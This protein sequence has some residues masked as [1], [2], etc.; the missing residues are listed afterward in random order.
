MF[1]IKTVRKAIKKVKSTLIKVDRRKW[2]ECSQEFENTFLLFVTNKCNLN[3]FH[4]FNRSNLNNHNVLDMNLQYVRK[5]VEAN[6]EVNKYDIMGGEP[7]LHK[8]INEI[9]E[10]LSEQNKKVGLYTNGYLLR[11]LETNHKN[12]KIGIST[13]SLYSTNKALRPLV[14]IS[15]NIKQYQKFYPIKLVFLI[16][17]HNVSILKKITEYVEKNFARINKLTIGLV[18]NE[19]DYWS[20]N[21]EYVLPFKE[22]GD[23]IQKFLDNYIGHLDIDIFTKG[24]L[25]THNLPTN[26]KHQI[27]RFK[28]IFPDMSYIPCLYLVASNKKFPIGKNYKIP[29]PQFNKCARTGKRRCMADK[30]CLINKEGSLLN[31]K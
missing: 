27:C 12:L 19:E 28:S 20:D 18:R 31:G 2:S 13:Q 29:F 30:I 23:I 21:Y 15:N 7:L 16:N 25:Y 24:V 6:P 22:Y 4:C 3:C 11:R 5:I 1:Q 26:Q 14:D 17:N 10:Y 8:N 9:I